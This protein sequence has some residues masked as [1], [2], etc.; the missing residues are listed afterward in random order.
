MGAGLKWRRV[1]AGHYEGRRPSSA[2]SSPD[3][4]VFEGPDSAWYVRAWDGERWL[5]EFGVSFRWAKSRAG[6]IVPLV[7]TGDPVR[8]DVR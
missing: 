3:A 7:A 6:D 5:V 2:G 8:C 1:R 4:Y